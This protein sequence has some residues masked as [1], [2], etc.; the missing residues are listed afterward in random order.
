MEAKNRLKMNIAEEILEWDSSESS[1]WW[2]Y[3]GWRA[4]I[5]RNIRKGMVCGFDEGVKL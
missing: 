3:F 1:K 4:T 5:M 2:L